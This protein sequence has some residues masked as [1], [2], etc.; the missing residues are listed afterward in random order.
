[1]QHNYHQS[2]KKSHVKWIN[3]QIKNIFYVHKHIIN[4]NLAV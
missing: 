1:M 4:C 3:C 2:I